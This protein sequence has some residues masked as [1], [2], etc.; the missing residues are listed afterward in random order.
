MAALHLCNLLRRP[1][2]DEFTAAA[3][4]IRPKVDYPVRRLD[5]VEVVLDHDDTVAA[6]HEAMQHVQQAI[7]IGE[8]QPSR[9]LVED[10]HRAAGGA[11]GELRGELDALRLTAREGRCRLAE[12]EIAESDLAQRLEA[13]ANRWHRREALKG[14]LHLQLQD[15][16]D[17]HSL[18]GHL[19]RLAVVALPLTRFAGHI[20]I[21]EELHLDLQ[22]AVA[23][24]G[25][26]AATLDVE[27]EA[28][29]RVATESRLLGSSKELT[30]WR[31]E[32]DVRCGVRARRTADWALVDLDYLVNLIEAG[33]A[34]VRPWSLFRAV[35]PAR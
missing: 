25:L 16:S 32:A 13:I 35:Q 31:E 8:V 24:T 11:T 30:D 3:S 27:G 29:S 17:R 26:A 18:P 7:N 34:V 14:I 33:D 15:I 5:Y 6:I 19:E 20:H 12:A 10:V 21:G 4:A 1:L 2:C 23:R 28:P 9:R 22:D